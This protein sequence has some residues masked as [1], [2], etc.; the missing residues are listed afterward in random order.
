M[1]GRWNGSAWASSTQ[2][3]NSPSTGYMGSTT[4][5]R[6]FDLTFEYDSNHLG[7]AIIVYGGT[8]NSLLSQHST[9][10]GATWGSGSL[11]GIEIPFPSTYNQSGVLDTVGEGTST[12]SFISPSTMTED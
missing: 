6:A 2:T 9:D 12:M 3:I 8:G 11:L 10:G 7:H 4:V 1:Y 5:N